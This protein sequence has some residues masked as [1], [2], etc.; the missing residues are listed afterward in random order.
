MSATIRTFRAPDARA[1]LAAVKAALG[2]EAVILSTR[3]VPGGMFRPTEIEVTAGKPDATGNPTTAQSRYAAFA[4]KEQEQVPRA[5]K[6]KAPRTPKARPAPAPAPAPTPAPALNDDFASLRELIEHPFAAN[7]YQELCGTGMEASL[8]ESLVK[9]TLE[10]HRVYNAT[11]LKKALKVVLASKLSTTEAPWLSK[12]RRIL[13]LVGP[14]GVGKTT[15]LAKI[16]ARALMESNR[17]VALITVDTYRIGA[18]EQV[19]RYGQIMNVPTHVARNQTELSKAIEHCRNADLVLIDTAG[20]S[21]S[22]AVAKQAELIRSVPSV[23]M[24]LV[25]SAATGSRELAHACDR[26]SHL[27]PERLLFTKVDEASGTGALLT[28]LLRLAAKAS[29]LADGQRVPEDLHALEASE[30]ADLI[31][32]NSV[33]GQTQHVVTG[34]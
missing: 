20:R 10:A 12:G 26:Y 5:P 1:A 6:A 22:E 32:G 30:W 9:D 2:P 25:L 4:R 21:T 3:E 17:S 8:A 27:Q 28:P 16:A 31:L 19:A 24:C 34:R 23:E 13:S 18:S 11:A 15:T 7:V 29:A 14:T 33:E